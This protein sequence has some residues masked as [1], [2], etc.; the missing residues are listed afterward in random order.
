M[1]KTI[2]VCGYGSGISAG[3]ARKF[4]SEGYRV[5]LVARSADK[6]E[7]GV[8]ALTE[9][10]VTA[11]AFPCDLSDPD[12]V[13]KMVGDVRAQ[14]G[15]VHTLHWNAYGGGAG[16]LTT[17]SAA[18]LR[19]TF[20]VGVTGAVMAVQG[21]LPDL[22]AERGAVIITGGGLAFYADPIDK[23]AVGWN[24]MDVALVKAAQHKLTGLLHQKLAPDGV[25]VGT[26]IVMGFVNGTAFDHAHDGSGL[27]PDDIAGAIWKQAT[28]RSES[29]VKFPG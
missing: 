13:T 26:L 7:A 15:P 21:A 14:L 17:C 23:M 24:A 18:A 25:F 20:D 16:D 4:G 12:A 29:V 28:E 8:R 2:I 11:K 9:A 1:S 22:K 6:L 10:G 27:N 19:R 5:A 3:V